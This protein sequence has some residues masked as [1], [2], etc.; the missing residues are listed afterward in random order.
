MKRLLLLLLLVLGLQ[1]SILAEQQKPLY[2][3]LSNG[4]LD[5]FPVEVYKAY[6]E[7]DSELKI[8]LVNDSVI[9]Y[10]A[11]EVDSLGAAPQLPE[12]TS[13]K[14]NNK[15]NDQVFVDVEANV[16]PDVVTATVGAI[17]KR[18][19][20]SFQLSSPTA[21]AYVNGVEQVSKVSR[22]R[23]DKTV[24]YVLTDSKARE[25]QYRKIQDEMWS[26]P[27]VKY[28]QTPIALTEEMLSTNAPTNTVSETL[29][30]ML[31][32]NIKT[33]FHSTWGNGEHKPLPLDEAP[34]IDIA[35]PEEISHFSFEYV[36]RPDAANKCPSEFS[37]QVSSDGGATW[38]EVKKLTTADGLPTNGY[39]LR[40]T[41]PIISA[42]KPF[43][44]VRLEMT[45]ATY[46]NYLCLAELVLTKAEIISITES[47][48]LQ[49]AIYAMTWMPSGRKVAVDVEWLTDKATQVPRIDINIEGGKMP[50][51]RETYLRAH[52]TIDGAGVFPSMQDSVNIRGRG[53]SSWAGETGKSPY[54]LKF[55]S[56]VK[57]F[58]L[59][60]GKSWVLLANR[61]TGSMLSN[62]MAMKVAAMIET[63]GANRI[64]PVELYMNGNYRGSYNFTQQCG[65][66]NNSIDLDDE[67]NAARLEL[68]TYY[69]ET[70]RFTTSA[71]SLPV[72]VKDPDL[73]EYAD[74]NAQFTLIKNDFNNL[75]NVL[76]N[77]G[78][79]YENLV[80]VDMLARFLLV[81]EL[82]MNLELRHPKSC[83]LYKEDLLAL[84]S[85]Y[86]F[87]PVWDF[88][89]AYGYE[90]NSQYCSTHPEVNYY[91]YFT[92]QNGAQFFKALRWNSEQVKRASYAEWKD[93][94]E[95][96][97]DE[98]I[99]YVDDYYAYAKPSILHNA[100][101]WSDGNNYEPIVERTKDWLRR[102]A[103][104]SF[105]ILTPYDLDTPL[106]IT[107]G[108]VN[109]DGY[110]TVADM[111]C[112]VNHLLQREN[113][114]FDFQQADVDANTDVTI[115]DL[116]HLVSLVM[117]QSV[118]ATRQMQLTPAEA[119]VKL[120]PFAVEEAET[121]AT[122]DLQFEIR[123]GAYSAT[124]FDVV[125]PAEMQVSHLVLPA[126]LDGFSHRL[127]QLDD[128]RYRI[129]V[130]SPAG[131]LLPVG[132]MS[133]ALHL[134]PL[135]TV[136][137]DRRVLS[138]D[139]AVLTNSVGEDCRVRPSSVRFQFGEATP[140]QQVVAPAQP[141]AVDIYDAGGRLIKQGA[142][143]LDGLQHGV[144]IIN[145]KKVIL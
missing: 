26:A 25:L 50:A 118:S 39:S 107:V 109:Q 65:F 20:P 57:P 125:V 130:Y 132:E 87:G 99:E 45:K 96:H 141:Q 111:V 129:I 70:Y 63:A 13:F 15:Y 71:Y 131:A 138:I 120:S 60:K 83:H 54:R 19:T 8:T 17:G 103:E 56:S 123:E 128:T 73:S 16:T 143:S 145:G 59:T 10:S 140:V 90:N 6:E 23:F 108:D 48:L 112:V 40:Y 33:I 5:I 74:P 142:K 27:E 9:V 64:I 116:V 79:A 35:L 51:D 67:T 21:K 52:I 93:F 95:N 28:K 114:T 92:S 134:S 89:W 14:F 98:L 100:Q 61:Q 97:L 31:D 41:S 122:A 2:I 115:N 58:G 121:S 117:N 22:L 91:D 49:P 62:A 7:N 32:G 76:R 110:I 133:I 124:Q 1:I 85:K 77:G 12:F 68:D 72:N 75:T 4:G 66:S 82:V 139:N 113:E 46:K 137:A 101:K 94:V 88:D 102:R 126:S 53:N 55:D 38:T 119:T 44:R 127:E 11:S 69:D 104:Y 106:P 30:K 81:N 84:H 36:T 29:G 47:E 78:S 3:Y 80:D 86:V 42:E 18:L 43:D 144:Y 24:T 135:A 105:G 37:V 34:Y 136:P